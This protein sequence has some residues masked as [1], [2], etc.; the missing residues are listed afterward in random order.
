MAVTKEYPYIDDMG[1]ERADLLR[2]YSDCGKM[3]LQVE[4]GVIYSEAVDVYPCRYTYEETAED[5]PA[6]KTESGD[7][8]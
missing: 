5:I 4:T 7:I 3:I 1:N 6:D 8:G 2:H